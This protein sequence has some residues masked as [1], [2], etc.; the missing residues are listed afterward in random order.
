MTTDSLSAGDDPRRLLLDIR[1]LTS[2]VRRD[3]RLT[4][5]ALLVLA[6]VTFAAIPFDW[7]FMTVHCDGSGCTFARRGMLYYWPPALLLA[8]A[9]IA[10]SYVR[11]ARARGL[12]ARVL[13]YAITGAVTAVVFAAAYTAAA[14]YFP[15]HPPFGGGP[16]PFWWI[17]LDRLIAPWGLIGLALLVLARLERNVAL[18]LFTLG[19]LVLMLLVSPTTD[20][21]NLPG[22][23]VPSFM[24]GASMQLPWSMTPSQLIIGAALLTAGI[25]FS[26][27]RRSQQ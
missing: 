16:L 11:A 13:P 12:G 26:R 25:A 23:A 4:Y 7:L 24:S 2:R 19:Y 10:V 17:V 14:A 8:Y 5:V 27:A 15:T 20:D 3:Q 18:L 9:A 1:T 22:W 21:T 6:A